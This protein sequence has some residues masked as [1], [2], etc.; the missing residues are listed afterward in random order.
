MP[1]VEELVAMARALDQ[2]SNHTAPNYISLREIRDYF[3]SVTWEWEGYIP[4]GH[5]TLLAGESGVGKSW[6]LAYL[7]AAHL[8]IQPYPTGYGVGAG[9]RVLLVETEELRGVYAERL[10]S[11]GVPDD[12]VILPGSDPTY[13]PAIA[14]DEAMLMDI[15]QSMGCSMIVVDSLSGGHSLEENSAEMR[16][17]LLVLARMASA[18]NV[19]MLVAHHTRKKGAFE[20]AEITLDRVRGSSAIVQ[21]ARSVLGL[22]KPDPNFNTVR[23]ESLKSSFAKKPAP[24]GFTISEDGLT[25][26]DA[27]EVP[28]EPTAVDKAIEFLRVRLARE[29]K[30]YQE[31]QEAAESE[32]I[33]KNSLYKAKEALGVITIN[34]KWS[35]PARGEAQE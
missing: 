16:S 3:G 21:F 15:A 2:Q 18:L 31:L 25:F 32:G 1:T 14:R 11:L 6:L 22:W 24:F 10:A 17:V 35:L 34:G 7:I 20:S 4:V 27:P 30:R 33:S 12:A 29:P 9:N 26:T 8:G 23:V 19:P 28:R 13:T 5:I